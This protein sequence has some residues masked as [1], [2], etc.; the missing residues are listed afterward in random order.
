MTFVRIYFHVLFLNFLCIL[1]CKFYFYVLKNLLLCILSLSFPLPS[2]HSYSHTDHTP[3]EKDKNYFNMIMMTL[4]SNRILEIT[5]LFDFGNNH[6]SLCSHKEV[7][8]FTEHPLKGHWTRGGVLKLFFDGMC[9]P[10]PE[11]LTHF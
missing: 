4:A 8:K 1:F 7:A 2:I 5:I 6:I 11:T 3:T 10:R 9:G